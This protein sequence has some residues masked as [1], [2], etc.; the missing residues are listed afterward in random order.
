MA[1]TDTESLWGKDSAFTKRPENRRTSSS[2]LVG[3]ISMSRVDSCKNYHCSSWGSG[4]N[5]VQNFALFNTKCTWGPKTLT[6]RIGPSSVLLN[7]RIGPCNNVISTQMTTQEKEYRTRLVSQNDVASGIR[8]FALLVRRP[9]GRY[10][11]GDIELLQQA[12]PI[13]L[14]QRL[15]LA[16]GERAQQYRIRHVGPLECTVCGGG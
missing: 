15:A 7:F 9:C 1:C 16:R 11:H 3:K 8:T 2:R 6:R 13:Q 4:E 5:C 14:P 12:V 10:A